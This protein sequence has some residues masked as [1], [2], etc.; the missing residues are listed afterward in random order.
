MRTSSGPLLAAAEQL[1]DDLGVD[2]GAAGGDARRG[3]DEVLHVGDA[4]LEQVADAARAARQQVRRVALLDVL[5]EDQDRGVGPAAPCL[6]GGA[7]ALVGLRRR[8]PHV[9]DRQ[10]GLVLVER[11]EQ[12]L[13][14]ADAGDDLVAVVGQQRRD[15]LAQQHEVLGDHDPHGSLAVIVV[16]PPVGAVDLE[17]AVE[18][19]DALGEALEA[20]AGH[21]PRAAVAVVA[22]REDERRPSS[23]RTSTWALVA[24]EWRPTLVS[25]SATT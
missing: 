8:H 17:R 25:V 23:R 10:V 18:R 12:R 2:H 16:G 22:D 5:A 20:R 3:G 24:P 4:V 11:G 9:D 6:D 19:L 14:V 13:A 7:D 21:A 1:G 15:A